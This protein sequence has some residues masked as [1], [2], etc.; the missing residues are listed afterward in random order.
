MKLSSYPRQGSN[1]GQPCEVC[2]N[3]DTAH[4]VSGVIVR[5]DV[6]APYQTIIRLD[7]GRYVRSV[8]CQYRPL[9]ERKRE[10]P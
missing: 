5:D 4:S 9:L 7:D 10:A 8:E 1:L 3:Y 6:E 2:F